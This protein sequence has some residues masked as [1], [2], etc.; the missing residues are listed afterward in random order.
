MQGTELLDDKYWRPLSAFGYKHSFFLLNS[1]TIIATW[2]L[3]FGIILFVLPIRYFLSKKDGIARNLLITISRVFI[4]FTQQTL[5]QFSFEHYAFSTSLFVFI[6]FSSLISLI[7]GLEEPTKDLNTPLALGLISFF[8]V[9]INAIRFAGIKAYIQ[10]F[11]SPFF[12]MLP[13]NIIGK[14]ATAISISFRL[15]GNVFGGF[16]ISNLYFNTLGSLATVLNTSLFGS[17]AL[18]FVLALPLLLIGG[19]CSIFMTAAFTFFEGALQAFVFFMLT[20]TYLSIATESD[21]LS[22]QESIT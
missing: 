9:Q 16:I 10:E 4:N 18:S 15:F 19:A 8:Y 5:K 1:E 17:Q 20:L 12:L 21:E 2:A 14:C 13:L 3:I 11:F 22:E 6:F 7:P